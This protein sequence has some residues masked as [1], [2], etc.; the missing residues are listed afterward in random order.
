MLKTLARAAVAFAVASASLHAAAQTSYDYLLLAASW[1]PG[2]CA[3]HDTP[4][5][6]NLAGSYAA[7]SLSLHGLW[8]NNYDGNQPFYCGVPQ[9]DVD[10]DNAHQWCS[11]DA[12]PISATTR[13]TLSTVMPG[14]ASCLD[15]HE[16]FKH[17]TCS[18]SAS[19]DA[20]WNQATGMISR[21]GN[22]SFNTYLQANA[23]KTVTRNQLLSA[24]E[25][26]FG[27]N[28]RSAV[29]LKCT[30]INGVSYFTEAWI[31]VKTNATAQF[32]SAASLV[33]DGN[34]QGTCPT[35]GVYI[36]K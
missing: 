13:N 31:A 14:V 9:S 35:S 11:M 25:G 20:Y 2:F 30:K 8:P 27:S 32:P 7:T 36:A 16:W 22:T 19:P 12:Y 10:L 18:N 5:C 28:T 34:T 23:G 21:L 3:S 33:T 24:F 1:E 4:E 15:K 29:S 26:A 6:T 17:G